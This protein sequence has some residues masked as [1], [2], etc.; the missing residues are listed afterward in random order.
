MRAGLYALA[1][2]L[3]ISI[4][5]AWAERLPVRTYGLASTARIKWLR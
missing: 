3:V 2:V 1:W 5:A 4:D